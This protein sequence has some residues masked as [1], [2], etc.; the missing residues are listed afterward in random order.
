MTVYIGNAVGDEHNKASGGEPGDQTGK[1]L[2]IQAWYLNKKGWRVFRAKD[3]ETAKRIAWC[4]RAACENPAIGYDQKQRNTLYTAAS[5]FDFDCS[6]VTTKCECDCSSLVRVC[7]AYAG[8]KMKDFNTVSEPTRLLATGLFVEMKD[9]KYTKK[10]EYLCI[11]DILCT[12]VK[13]H[14]A[15][16]LN[17]G[18]KADRDPEPEPPHT[19]KKVKVIGNRVHVRRGDNKNTGILFTALKGQCFPY[20]ATAPTGWYEIDTE[21]GLG[22]ISNR[23][24]LTRLIDT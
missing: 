14:T 7:C 17:D 5:P 22:Y 23:P 6:K 16:V 13:G 20:I 4:M 1:E 12:S 8:I 18:P 3:A 11:G 9:D 10:S 15:V 2:K 19:D 21:K 24:D